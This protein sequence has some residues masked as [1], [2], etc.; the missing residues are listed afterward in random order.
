MLNTLSLM[1]TFFLRMLWKFLLWLKVRQTNQSL[2]QTFF[3]LIFFRHSYMLPSICRRKL[4][5]INKI[6][7]LFESI[8]LLLESW[9]CICLKKKKEI[10][11]FLSCHLNNTYNYRSKFSPPIIIDQKLKP[12]SLGWPFNQKV[13]STCPCSVWFIKV[14]MAFLI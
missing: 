6:I 13:V 8:R 3:K 1:Q 9:V 10:N 7:F 12:P 11:V 2:N 4:S 14:N 5:S